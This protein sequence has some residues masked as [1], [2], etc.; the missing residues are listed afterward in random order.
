MSKIKELLKSKLSQFKEDIDQTENVSFE[1]E[2]QNMINEINSTLEIP[3][4][5]KILKSSP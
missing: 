2:I 3:E 5:S 1:P 4:S